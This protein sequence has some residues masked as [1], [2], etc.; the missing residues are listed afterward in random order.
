[1]KLAC[2][3][4]LFD[5]FQFHNLLISAIVNR[6]YE[7]VG[8]TKQKMSTTHGL[9]Q[10]ESCKKQLTLPTQ[11]EICKKQPYQRNRKVKRSKIY[12]FQ[13]S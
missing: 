11:L 13:E 3:H 6:Q 9:M 8:C 2:H 12:L 5:F 10:W 4:S 1:M 7:V